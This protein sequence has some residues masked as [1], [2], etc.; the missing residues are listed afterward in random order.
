[1][2]LKQWSISNQQPFTDE[3]KFDFNEE[4]NL[5]IGPNGT[6]KSTV[7]RRLWGDLRDQASVVIPAH[8]LTLPRS[9][10][11]EG[12]K[13]LARD[14][15][16]AEQIGTLLAN[17]PHCFDA[18]RMHFIKN[19]MAR[20][21]L[22]GRQP[23]E[24]IEQYLRARDM[25]YRCAQ[26]ICGELL[27]ESPP[28][29][30]VRKHTVTVSENVTSAGG[31][32]TR[33]SRA[34]GTFPYSYDGM[35]ITVTHDVPYNPLG[36]FQKVFSGDLSDGTQGTLSW[37]EYMA[38]HI[39]YRHRFQ[40]GWDSHPATLLID[41]IE[42]HLH[43][44]WQRRVLPALRRYFPQVQIFA[45]TH[46]P[47]F[48][49]GLGAGQVHRLYRDDDLVVRV[50]APNEEQIV[51]W[52][53]DEILRGLMGVLD[54]TDRKTALR[55]EELRRLQ[56][57]IPAENPADDEGRLQRI[58]ELQEQVRPAILAGGAVA[59]DQELFE[60]QFNAAL[61]RYR[62]SQGTEPKQT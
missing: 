44:E 58:A 19:F 2:P 45:T 17:N 41:E 30:Y 14:S 18:K 3:V 27:S 34:V 43:P 62:E 42:N 53:M 40:A 47:F 37:I 20:E 15:D 35:A 29:T 60:Q 49:A 5:F 54:P 22:Q 52:T 46:S 26:M 57:Q 25:A 50:E 38:V 1:M 10:D 59:A 12:Q 36:T 9:S 13:A 11:E 23:G 21:A 33:R 24:A 7:I 16:D 32:T 39:C 28:E 51:G 55:T 61:E 8:R 31:T 6:G 56:N 4:I 48:V